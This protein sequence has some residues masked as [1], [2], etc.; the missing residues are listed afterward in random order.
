[1]TTKDSKAIGIMEQEVLCP[2]RKENTAE[3]SVLWQ[4]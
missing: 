1:M 2:Y 3:D 4:S